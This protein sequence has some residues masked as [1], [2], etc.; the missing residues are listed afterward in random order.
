MLV[1]MLEYGT[2]ATLPGLFPSMLFAHSLTPFLLS[3]MLTKYRFFF[4]FLFGLGLL[5]SILYT[6]L[7]LLLLLFMCYCCYNITFTLVIF[8]SIAFLQC[9]LSYILHNEYFLFF[10]NVCVCVCAFLSLSLHTYISLAFFQPQLPFDS[11]LKCFL[12]FYT[13]SCSS[14]IIFSR[15]YYYFLVHSLFVCRAFDSR[16]QFC[17]LKK[18]Y[19]VHCTYINRN[20]WKNGS[21]RE[22]KRSGNVHYH[23]HFHNFSHI[24]FEA[25]Y[26][27]S[28][29]KSKTMWNNFFLL[30]L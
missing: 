11:V 16:I 15:Q 8:H 12:L 20:T 25:H 23:H 9:L 14:S 1:L 19:N 13:S 3:Y 24:S 18:L 22:E 29:M 30:N 26:S 4:L 17:I 21:R 5:L 27:L 2:F 10:L 6:D 7:Y 28:K